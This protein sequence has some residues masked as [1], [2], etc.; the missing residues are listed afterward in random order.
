MK[1]ILQR[2]EEEGHLA[3]A[4]ICISFMTDD[5]E[6]PFIGFFASLYLVGAVPVPVWCPL[7]EVAYFIPI[8]FEDY[9]YILD[10]IPY[11]L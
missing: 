4:L 2:E 7:W 10:L 8:D 5:M 3:E 1:N 11:Q 6:H 9:L